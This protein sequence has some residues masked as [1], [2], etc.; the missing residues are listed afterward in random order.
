MTEA[1]GHDAAK[2]LVRSDLTT[3]SSPGMMKSKGHS[4]TKGFAERTEASHGQVTPPTAAA[5]FL[6]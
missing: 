2:R 4:G 6:W 5:R 3:W 1:A